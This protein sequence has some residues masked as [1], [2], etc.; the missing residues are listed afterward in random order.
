MYRQIIR[1]VLVR[2]IM[3]RI[4]QPLIDWWA[5][6]NEPT[7]ELPG[8]FLT[9]FR[10]FSRYSSRQS[11]A[12]AFY[13]L[14]SVFPLTLLLAVLVGGLLEPAVAQ[15]QIANGLSFFLPEGTVTYV[16]DVLGESL[17][18]SSSFG[19]VAIVAIMWSSLGLFSNITASLDE[20]FAV[21]EGRSIW[22][23][24]FLAVLMSMT[25]VILVI[26][27]FVTSGVLR[28]VS[29]LLLDQPSLWVTIGILFL[30]FGL[31]VVIFSMLFRFVP[32][33]YVH[34]DAVLP[35]AMF[36]AVGWELAKAGFGYY[37]NS[38]ATFQF[39]YGSIA[40][41]IVLLFWANLIAAI[42]LFSAELCA[43]LNE[44][45]IGQESA[46]VTTNR[47]VSISLQDGQFRVQVPDN[48]D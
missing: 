42:F 16:Q 48:T 11:A 27:S 8:V 4:F 24:R 26:A 31:D 23:L 35:A 44:W 14:F 15:E 18:Q 28:L 5:T 20:I 21:P 7:R 33:R 36:G 19:F 12:L 39:I 1:I 37:L 3:R 29:I 2:E 6:H 47:Q 45:I 41:G 34:W 25:L 30:P 43:R 40:T 46:P 38:L 22:G 32:A 10:N 9:A 17:Q 13:S